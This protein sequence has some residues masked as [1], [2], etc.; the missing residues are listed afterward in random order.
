MLDLRH[1]LQDYLDIIGAATRL[2]T[3]SDRHKLHDWLLSRAPADVRSHFRRFVEAGDIAAAKTLAIWLSQ[4]GQ[5]AN[6]PGHKGRLIAPAL[7]LAVHYGHRRDAVRELLKTGYTLIY[8]V[9]D[10]VAAQQGTSSRALFQ[11]AFDGTHPSC[12]IL[13]LFRGSYDHL[14]NVTRSISKEG[15]VGVFWSPDRRYAALHAVQRAWDDPQK[16]ECGVP[17]IASCAVPAD[18]TFPIGE[19]GGQIHTVIAFDTVPQMLDMSPAAI[20]ADAKSYFA[21]HGR[22]PF[23]GG[24]PAWDKPDF[25]QR[26]RLS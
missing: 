1:P 17:V 14:S 12:E 8:P 19:R 16:G 10:M 6:A 11:Y 21:Q 3:P 2:P 5:K 23:E 9:I 15:K 24:I 20:L 7:I 26:V 13:T 22:Y 4:I 18:Q 25:A